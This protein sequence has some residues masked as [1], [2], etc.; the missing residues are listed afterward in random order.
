MT[1]V[2]TLALP[3][4]RG[5]L[6]LAKAPCALDILSDGRVIAGLGPGSSKGTALVGSDAR[7]LRG[8]L[9][10]ASRNAARRT[11]TTVT[12]PLTAA[13]ATAAAWCVHGLRA[14]KA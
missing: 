1:L 13:R 5:P 8:R 4:L 9:G 3:A 2:T 7:A 14:R 11:L 10:A 12:A 6:P